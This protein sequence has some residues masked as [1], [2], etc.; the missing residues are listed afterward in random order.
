MVKKVILILIILYAFV[1]LGFYFFQGYLIFRPKKLASDFNY[2]FDVNFEEVY[3]KVSDNSALN[4]LH[5]KVQNPKGVILYF[6]GN[7][8]N[9]KRWG[10]IVSK[11]TK[12][13][14]DVFV[15]DYRG[16]GKS[17]GERTQ[18]LMYKDAQLCYNYLT[19][20][21][22]ESTIVIY[23]RSLGGIFASYVASK[24]RPKYLILEATFNSLQE[25]MNGKFPLLPYSKLLKF[26]F[27]SRVFME[28]VQCTTLIFHGRKDRLIPIKHAEVLLEHSNRDKTTFVIIEEGTHHNLSEFPNYK[29]HLDMVLDSK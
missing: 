16:Y 2:S 14:Y 3:L 22:D 27:N 20:Q 21:Y 17:T 18:D 10:G 23:G 19:A 29:K 26:E 7:K 12:Y 11:F 5:F 13:N 15:I 8:D 24:N 28:R 1:F 6:H 25:V 4:A 9:L